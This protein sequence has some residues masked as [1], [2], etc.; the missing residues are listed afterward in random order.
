MGVGQRRR[1]SQACQRP[2]SS[3][4]SPLEPRGGRPHGTGSGGGAFP[5]SAPSGLASSCGS[6]V[7][8]LRRRRR[9]RRRYG[10]KSFPVS[11]L[12]ARA[13]AREG[14]ARPR[15]GRP[16][17]ED[18]GWGSRS[19][20]RPQPAR[21]QQDLG[22]GGAPAFPRMG[23]NRTPPG[24]RRRHEPDFPP[25]PSSDLTCSR[26][27]AWIC[28]SSKLGTEIGLGLGVGGWGGKGRAPRAMWTRT[29]GAAIDKSVAQ[30]AGRERRRS[31]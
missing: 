16:P 7:K 4:P 6:A 11:P 12:G 29:V 1:P 19:I 5:G 20:Q 24:C 9:R 8:F 13:S 2:P 22:G 3:H 10:R 18:P 17:S 30:A 23:D 26:V 21:P 14:K 28:R 25:P 31:A 15:S 27:K